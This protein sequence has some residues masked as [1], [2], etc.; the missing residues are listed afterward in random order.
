VEY[1]MSQTSIGSVL[2]LLL[3]HVAGAA[4]VEYKQQTII[5]P[6][7]QGGWLTPYLV[8]IDGDGLTDLLV[9]LSA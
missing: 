5:V 3:A 4:A 7:D 9:L 1:A 8:D 2:L 6:S